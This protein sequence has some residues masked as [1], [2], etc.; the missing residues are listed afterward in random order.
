LVKNIGEGVSQIGLS[1]SSGLHY[2]IMNNPAALALF[3][4][5]RLNRRVIYFI[6]LLFSFGLYAGA[7]SH[8]YNMDD[9]LVTKGHRLT[10]KGFE[11][12]AEILSSPYYEDKMGYSYEYRPIVHIS[13]AIEHGLFGESPRCSHLINILLHSLTVLLVFGVARML[14]AQSS[15]LFAVLAALL[16]AAHPIHTEVV[17]N[18]KNR[19]E[20]LALFFILMSLFFMLKALK[21]NGWTYYW[22]CIPV[23]LI[24]S[25]LSKASGAAFLFLI[26]F[27]G[28]LR[29]ETSYAQLLGLLISALVPLTIYAQLKHLSWFWISNFVLA[30]AA[31]PLLIMFWRL[32]K[33]LDVLRILQYLRPHGWPLN[34]GQSSSGASHGRGLEYIA[35]MVVILVG[36][37]SLWLENA[38][39]MA[40]ILCILAISPLWSKRQQEFILAL[41]ILAA[42]IVSFLGLFRGVG[43][44]LIFYS[45]TVYTSIWIRRELKYNLILLFVVSLPFL[46]SEIRIIPKG[47]FPDYLTLSFNLLMPIFPFFATIVFR[48]FYNTILGFLWLLIFM[49]AVVDFGGGLGTNELFMACG[50]GFGLIYLG[51]KHPVWLPR[52]QNIIATLLLVCISVSVVMPL[53]HTHH[54]LPSAD[55]IVAQEQTEKESI[56]ID[57]IAEATFDMEDRPLVFAEYPLDSAAAIGIRLGTA[58]NILG[59]YLKMMFIPYPQAFYYGYDEVPIGNIGELKAISFV[60]LHLFLVFA[61]LYFWRH[62]PVLSL[63]IGMYLCSIALFSNLISPVAG[64]MADRLAYV[65]SFGFCI[66]FGYAVASIYERSFSVLSRRTITVFM[67]ILLVTCSGMTIARNAKWKD[68]L[69]LMRND[70]VHVPNSAQAHNLLASYL[71]RNSYLPEY[72]IEAV[73]MQRE[74]VDHLKQAIRIWPE[75]FNAWY[76]LGRV[77]QTLGETENAIA[78]YKEVHRQDSTYF[79]ATMNVAFLSEKVGDV[80]TA[81]MFYERCIRFNPEMQPAYSNLSYLYF[82]SRMFAE[83]IEV[84]ERAIAGHPKWAE[85]YEHI[86]QT[87]DVMGESEKAAAYRAKAADL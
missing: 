27:Y 47:D 45:L 67:V 69:T 19:D 73:S 64:M 85:P 87:Y 40:S 58:S 65:A 57:L 71:M 28:L 7:I 31:P 78:C 10:S 86:A 41:T 39:P 66:A 55:L 16:F 24:L 70:I 30:I 9:S 38:I 26:P 76:D 72:A 25:L 8:D 32:L 23:F 53:Y 84:N 74:A 59:H 29:K 50:T 15:I 5:T 4:D 56:V 49:I 81:I 82:R 62:H 42:I 51:L 83:S 12:I 48:N 6:L 54:I 18:I 60:V 79:D 22:I 13:F 20:L 21:T 33:K 44:L 52:P 1:K 43:Y 46:I 34:D 75:F 80:S 37:V 63:A 14:S 35:L 61:V 68:A 17:A 3:V 77:Y 36:A 11:G 2:S